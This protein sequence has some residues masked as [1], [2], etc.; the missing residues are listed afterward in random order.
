MK[1]RNSFLI[2]WLFITTEV[3]I[4]KSV[5]DAEH[6]QSG[7]KFR[8]TSVEELNQW[9]KNINLRST[10]TKEHSLREAVNIKQTINEE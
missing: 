5:L 8:T 2:R 4:E 7:N 10:Q 9:M 6:I 1:V 3:E